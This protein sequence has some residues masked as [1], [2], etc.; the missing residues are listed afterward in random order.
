MPRKVFVNGDI[1]DASDVNTYF[2][3]Q[4]VQVFSTTAAR[5]AA[6][7]APTLGMFSF[8]TSTDTIQI[9]TSA[10]WTSQVAS[11]ADGAVTT[12]KL[13]Q[14]ASSEAVTT[15]TI[16]AGAV[17]TA[18]LASSLTLTTPTLGVATATSINGL[19]LT[20]STGT[21]SIT[22]GKTL[23]ASNSITLAGNDSSTISVSGNT[24]LG[25]STHTLTLTTTGNTTLALPTTGTVSTVGGTETLI[26]KT[27]TSPTINTPTIDTPTIT[28]FTFNL[29]STN[30]LTGTKAQFN[31]A[32]SDAN[33]VTTT[34]SAIVSETMIDYTTVPKQFVQSGTPS[35]K[36]GDIWIKTA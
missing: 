31:T 20:A 11:I 6:I 1:L 3:D 21:L 32:L 8:I 9:Y 24:T 33:F 29:G 10:G 34:D 25:S 36:A 28:S 30:S 27:I 26:N 35:G 7:P 13:N 17:T 4:A 2:M 14:T 18:K 12:A 15:A 5:L 22:N 23:S 16:R 19:T